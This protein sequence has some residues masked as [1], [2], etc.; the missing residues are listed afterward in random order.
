MNI[1]E[2][3]KKIFKENMTENDYINFTKY[4]ESQCDNLVNYEF[5]TN[6]LDMCRIQLQKED[7]TIIYEC[8]SILYR[9][10][11]KNYKLFLVL[12]YAFLDDYP[13]R[14]LCFLGLR[15]RQNNFIKIYNRPPCLSVCS[16]R[17]KTNCSYCYEK[18]CFIYCNCGNE[19]LFRQMYEQFNLDSLQKYHEIVN[20]LRPGRYT[21]PAI[22]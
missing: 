14:N 2:F 8:V 19:D 13:V 18:T 10:L 15:F 9:A 7:P 20:N 1:I 22:K 3:H 12:L 11:C 21:K 4:I 16:C 5:I 6:S 17:N